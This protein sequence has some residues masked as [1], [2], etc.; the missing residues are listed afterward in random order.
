MKSQPLKFGLTLLAQRG[1][2]N[3]R[4]AEIFPGY[5]E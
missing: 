1:N 5:E 4:F 2:R 3:E